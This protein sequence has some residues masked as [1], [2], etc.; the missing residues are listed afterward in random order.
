MAPY[1]KVKSRLGNIK[2]AIKEVKAR[3][4]E[5]LEKNDRIEIAM[6]KSDA[7]AQD[8][9]KLMRDTADAANP[10]LKEMGLEKEG[11]EQDISEYVKILSDNQHELYFTS[12][13]VDAKYSKNVVALKYISDWLDLLNGSIE[14]VERFLESDTERK[15]LTRLFSMIDGTKLP[16]KTKA[17]LKE[18]FL[19]T[20]NRLNNSAKT[21]EVAQRQDSNTG[22][23]KTNL[24]TEN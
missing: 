9:F 1:E 13:N 5:V 20:L 17:D 24:R 8:L 12:V 11:I 23:S 15:E 7:Y 10:V 21:E 4:S 3:I 18:E 16:A 2:E 22:S 19:A 14:K 6:I